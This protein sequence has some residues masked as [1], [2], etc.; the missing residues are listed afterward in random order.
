[1]KSVRNEGS[2]DMSL[3][4][5]HLISLAPIN[6][7]ISTTIRETKMPHFQTKFQMWIQS[8]LYMSACG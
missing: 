8:S 5:L 3:Q 2:E 1:M 7:Y 6:Y 4:P